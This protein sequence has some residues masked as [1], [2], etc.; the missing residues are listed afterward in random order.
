[1]ELNSIIFPSPEFVH[2]LEEHADEIAYIPKIKDYDEEK[3]KVVGYIPCLILQC[4]KKSM[5]SRNFLIYFHGNAEDIF[6]AREI[7][8]RIRQNLAVR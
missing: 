1:M 4:F 8:D 6:Y 5:L 7:A 3:E 2:N